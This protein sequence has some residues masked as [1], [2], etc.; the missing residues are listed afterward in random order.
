ME[1]QQQKEKFIYFNVKK[2]ITRPENGKEIPYLL[3]HTLFAISKWFSIKIHRII[4]SDEICSHDHPWPFLTVILK[5]GYYEWT[6]L[7]KDE[8]KGILRKDD[9]GILTVRYAPDGIVEAKRW[10]GP[11][12]ILYRPAKSRH[13]LELKQGSDGKLIPAKTLV[14]TGKVIRKWG[15]FTKKGWLHWREYD[16]Q[17]DCN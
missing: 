3:R 11:G 13:Q 8:K 1:T 9:E 2:T 14:F 6:P 7:Y 12:S 17:R 5:G 16:K 10:H 4:E 15:F